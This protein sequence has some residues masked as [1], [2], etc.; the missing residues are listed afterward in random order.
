[1]SGV[2]SKA[3]S[4]Q[5]KANILIVDDDQA[6]IL[7]FTKILEVNGYENIISTFDPCETIPLQQKH[8]FALILLDINMPGMNGFEVLQQLQDADECKDTQVIATSGN[9][10]TSF[11]KEALEAGFNDYITKPMR[12]NEILEK[13][14]GALH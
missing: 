5:L 12:M 3:H 14:S 4:E 2:N 11:I 13:V 9:I 6:N 10:E 7:L 1:M 8:Q